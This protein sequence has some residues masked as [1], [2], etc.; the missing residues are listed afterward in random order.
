M[1]SQCVVFRCGTRRLTCK[2]AIRIMLVD[3]ICF[4]RGIAKKDTVIEQ[5]KRAYNSGA[6]LP[7]VGGDSFIF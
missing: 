7:C 3:D 5:L 6:T 4:G 2:H 1:C